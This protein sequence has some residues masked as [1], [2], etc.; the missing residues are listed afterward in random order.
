MWFVCVCVYLFVIIGFIF[1]FWDSFVEDNDRFGVVDNG[2][3]ASGVDLVV[4]TI[5]V[6]CSGGFAKRQERGALKWFLLW[7]LFDLL[8]SEGVGFFSARGGEGGGK[9]REG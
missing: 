3:K 8:G 6:D 7:L 2:A 1:R 5:G 4:C 9:E